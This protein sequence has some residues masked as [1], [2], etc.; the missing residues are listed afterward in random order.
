[1]D[2]QKTGIFL[3]AF[4]TAA[5]S[6][7]A[8]ES[9]DRG[10]SVNGYVQLDHMS[11]FK[12]KTGK[13]NGRNQGIVQMDFF[14]KMGDNHSFFSTVELRDDL[15][16]KSRNR[17]YV[18]EAYIDLVFEK[19]DLRAGKQVFSW[20]KADGFNP[21]NTLAPMDYTDVLDTDDEKIGIF[22][23]NA[24]YYLGGYEIQAVFSPVFTG[25]VFPSADSRWQFGMPGYVD[26]QGENYRTEYSISVSKPEQK[27]KNSS[28]ALKL[29]KNFS[30]LDV[31]LS[32]FC[33]YRHV[34]EI[35]QEIE[36]MDAANK[37]MKVD[38]RQQYYRQQVIS[39]DF[40]FVLDKYVLKGEGGLHFPKG[41][42]NDSPYFQYVTGIDRV[43]GSTI[44]S[45]NLTVILQWMHELKSGKIG[46]S[47]RDFN[48][49]FQKNVMASLEQELSAS[50]QIS[51]QGVYALKY[52]DFYLRPKLA[53][54]ISDG[55]NLSVSADVLGGKK[56]KNGLFSGFSDNNRAHIRL[57]YGF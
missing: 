41:I 24:K 31:S 18:E 53:H 42:P 26:V 44:G 47:G 50:T 37:T 32:Y 33:G 13:V 45:N 1:M 23:L 46:Y 28:F 51:L 8:Q 35:L 22:A 17:V 25:T 11:F 29:A 6:V 39:G 34:P 3:C 14:S 38:I 48:H 19:W 57:K 16:D 56:A 52:E 10:I 7:S 30:R 5:F 20:G 12:E 43:F 27:L 55:L 40:S 36:G 4:A 15:S 9:G 2:L 54:N 21:M 49:L